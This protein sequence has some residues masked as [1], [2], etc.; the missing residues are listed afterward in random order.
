M[1]CAQRGSAGRTGGLIVTAIRN[2]SVFARDARGGVSTAG[3]GG[4]LVDVMALRPGFSPRLAGENPDHVQVLSEA[5]TP[6]PP[7][8]V[9][10]PSMR[11][12]D[13][14]HRLKATIRLGLDTIAVDFFDGSEESAFH[15]ALKLNARNGYP[16]TSAD[17]EA[18]VRRVLS[19]HPDWSDRAIATATGISAKTVATVRGRTAMVNPATRVGQDGRVRPLDTNEGRLRASQL[20]EQNPAASLREVASVAGISVSTAH[21]VRQ[22]L[23]RGQD[24]LPARNRRAY[25]GR[26]AS[27]ATPR[28]TP[29]QATPLDRATILSNLRRDPSLRLNETSRRLVQLLNANALFPIERWESLAANVPEHCRRAISTLASDYATAWQSL[30]RSLHGQDDELTAP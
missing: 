11:V 7:I 18:A 28:P 1:N 4:V 16:L 8:L 12:I 25:E 27:P 29:R 2:V 17:R 26:T 13:G 19:V 23:R 14:M 22:R 24:P 20:M 15:M 21:D 30:A 5:E 10:R 9:H 3:T 6:M